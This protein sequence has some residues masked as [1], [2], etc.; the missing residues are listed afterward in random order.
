MEGSL[1]SQ[2]APPAALIPVEES[3]AQRLQRSQARFRDRGGIFV[4]TARN[5]LVD[6]LLGRKVASPKKGRGRS[7]SVSPKK[8]STKKDVT[9]SEEEEK[10]L[11]RSPRKAAHKVLEQAE[12]GPSKQSS[13]SE[14]KLKA[15]KKSA[16]E[17]SATATTPS[18]AK[19]TPKAK[20]ADRKKPAVKRRGQHPKTFSVDAETTADTIGQVPPAQGTKAAK[21]EAKS[22]TEPLPKPKVT[23]TAKATSKRP[24]KSKPVIAAE[25]NDDDI[26]VPS[27]ASS[28]KSKPTASRKKAASI[29]DDKAK[30]APAKQQPKGKKPS[31]STK[32]SASKDAQN[33]NEADIPESLK[34]V[35]SEDSNAK[36]KKK[37]LQT[38]TTDGMQAVDVPTRKVAKKRARPVDQEVD[39]SS[40][41]KRA[42]LTS[43]EK[44]AT[45][46]KV[47]C[48]RKKA[49]DAEAKEDAPRSP[50]LK[51]RAREPE[52]DAARTKR[53]KTG[54]V[55]PPP[56]TDVTVAFTENVSETKATGGKGKTKKPPTS[57][58][59]QAKNSVAIK[60][61]LPDKP[62]AK[63]KAEP[64]V[65]LVTRLRP[66]K[67][68]IVRMKQPEPRTTN[69]EPDP[70]DF[71]R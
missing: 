60:N 69:N 17:T 64:G 15:V 3:R 48:R 9:N 49:F 57:K 12:A 31:K 10:A 67:S 1:V 56:T 24:S 71:L 35:Q 39:S 65:V 46:T 59:S 36:G 42:K 26:K 7:A 33:N 55:A 2:A 41:P 11:R 8:N 5:T 38:A 28:S 32:A 13:K 58:A 47:P 14:S 63:A 18:R 4:P 68:V 61:S 62:P 19:S 27:G 53:A 23:R 37:A 22:A 52:T 44:A 16:K 6:I 43:P 34:G 54:I 66:R 21:S 29:M 50:A 70:I 40:P 30:P 25:D 51:K 45:P 20:A